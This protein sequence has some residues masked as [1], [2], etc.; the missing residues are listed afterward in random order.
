MPSPE[1]EPG[2]FVGQFGD[3][4]TNK[5][6]SKTVREDF[7]QAETL[8]LPITLVIL[9]LAFGALTAAGVPCCSAYG[10][11]RGARPGG[12]S[13]A[14]SC[15][16]TDAISSVMLLIGLAV[17]VDYWLFYLRREREER[18]RGGSTR[19]ALQAAAATSGRAVLVSGSTVMIAM[20]GMFLAGN[21]TFIVVRDRHDHGRRHRDAR[22]GHRAAG[23][24]VAA[25][26]SR[27]A[28]PRSRSGA[29]AARATAERAR[30]VGASSSACCGVRCRPWC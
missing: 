14:T 1:R 8:S 23:R 11:H 15:P 9:L 10:S 22:L 12:R 30:L 21:A 6:V 27:R 28:R 13:S 4:S 24:A 18:A 3:A 26:R 17:G 20:A 5:A 2:V 16:S 19:E 7:A 25:R 29:L